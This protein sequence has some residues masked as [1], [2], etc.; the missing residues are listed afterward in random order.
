MPLSFRVNGPIL[1]WRL[2]WAAADR[3]NWLN[4]AETLVLLASAIRLAFSTTASSMLRVSFVMVDSP[5]RTASSI[6]Y[7]SNDLHALLRKG[8][9][10]GEKTCQ[11]NFSAR[12]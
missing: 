2:G 5:I 12:Q 4:M 10:N 9:E 3:T 6:L 8:R 1:A 11:N 7:V